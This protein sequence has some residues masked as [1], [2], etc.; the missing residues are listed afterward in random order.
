MALSS[1]LPIAG[2]LAAERN[3]ANKDLPIF[4]AHGQFDDIIPIDRARKS[5][6]FLLNLG[7]PVEWHEYPMPHSVCAPEIDHIS[8]FLVRIL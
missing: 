7:Y 4:M 3:E 1:Y 5:R 6:D 8:Q 2:S